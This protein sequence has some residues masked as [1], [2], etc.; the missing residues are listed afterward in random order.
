M[1]RC[2]RCLAPLHRDGRCPL[3]DSRGMGNPIGYAVFI[4]AAG[5]CAALA[6]YFLYACFS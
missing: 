3:C 6:I 2:T 1:K 4:I 5:L